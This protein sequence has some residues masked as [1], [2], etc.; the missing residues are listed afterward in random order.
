[1][2][3]GSGSGSGTDDGFSRRKRRRRRSTPSYDDYEDEPEL[4]K[5]NS[6][7]AKN[8]LTVMLKLNTDAYEEDILMENGTKT[9]EYN[10][11]KNDFYGFRV[12][13]ALM[14]GM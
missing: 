4:R 3:G 6:A 11:A 12:R 10:F 8:G 5:L 7:S 2:S 9:G 1:M 14:Y 13:S